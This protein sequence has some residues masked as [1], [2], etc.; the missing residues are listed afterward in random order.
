MPVALKPAP[1]VRLTDD[2]PATLVFANTTWLELPL[3]TCTVIPPLGAAPF[4]RIFVV[5]SRFWPTEMVGHTRPA[6]VTLAVTAF[7]PLA[8]VL[9]PEGTDAV[10]VV[11]PGELAV[12]VAFAV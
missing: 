5:V 12:N 8:G 3:T 6:G 2:V 9:K 7:A 11:A 10:M 4:S 1:A